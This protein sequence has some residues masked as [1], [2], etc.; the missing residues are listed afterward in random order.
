MSPQTRVAIAWAGVELA[1][2]EPAVEELPDP[3]D[4][5]PTATSSASEGQLSSHRLGGGCY[6]PGCWPEGTLAGPSD[7]RAFHPA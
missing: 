3:C 4:C 1:K 5:E 6:I 2:A 7:K